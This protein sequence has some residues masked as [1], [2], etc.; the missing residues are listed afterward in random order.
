MVTKA[1]Q[2]M[3]DALCRERYGR[4]M[5]LATMLA[6]PDEAPDLV[7][8]A[9]IAVFA[10]HRRFASLNA[11]DAYVRRAIATRF[12]DRGRRR[13]R[14]DATVKRLAAQTP[15]AHEDHLPEPRPDLDLALMELPPRVR[16]CVVLRYL[17]DLSVRDTAG[18]LGLSEGAVKRYVSDGLAALNAR[19]GTDARPDDS[20][21][22]PVGT[23]RGQR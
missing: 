3:F 15:A 8:D 12:I 1:S 9:M 20:D 22:V 16:A 18:A 6:G 2:P 10:K 21:R 4:L 13:T 11:A 5:A 19:L 14:H 17:D 23:V 7:H